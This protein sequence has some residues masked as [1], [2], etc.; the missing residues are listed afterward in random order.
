MKLK[1]GFLAMLCLFL[2]AA[3]QENKSIGEIREV[4]VGQKMPDVLITGA[5]GL[6]VGGRAVNSFRFSDL[7]GRLVLLDFW[8][9]WCSPCRAMVPVMD[10]LQREFGDQVLFL[11]VA[12]Q[13]KEVIAPVL[14]AMQKVRP[15]TLPGVTGDK[16]LV[17]IFPH[18][19]L[20]HFV[21][22][23][24][25]G[26]VVAITE[27]SE[28]T[29]AN[30]R[31][32][33]RGGNVALRQKKDVVIPYDV[34]KPLLIA[35]NGGEGSAMTYH[36]VLSGYIPGIKGGMTTTLPDSVKGRRFTMRNVPVTWLIR[37]AYTDHDRWLSGARI[38]LLSAD[39]GRMDTK[40][41]GQDAEHW[42]SSGNGWCYELQVPPALNDSVYSIL[43]ADV[44]RLFPKYQVG[45]EQVKTRCL[46]LVR[47]SGEDKLRSEGGTFKVEVGPF[48]AE[49]HNSRLSQL[50]RRLEV[51]YLQNSPYPIVDETGYNAQVDLSLQGQMSSV[52]ALN[53]ALKKYDLAFVEKDAVTELLVVRDAPAHK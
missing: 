20:P 15:F 33:L 51:Q 6:Q 48:S 4:R 50:V 16:V 34:D 31:M 23:N 46:V 30:I 47:T 42:I 26:V 11:P 37:M 12:Y 41:S 28:V 32:A 25:D 43:Q 13:S 27:E 3:A 9:T 52:P 39:S 40:L 22:I 5:S 38:R 49:L 36:S 8:A 2:R 21:W 18:R 45:V 19:F 29:G 44:R 17:K 24:G 7:K 53:L 35:G 1:I 14:A 10:S